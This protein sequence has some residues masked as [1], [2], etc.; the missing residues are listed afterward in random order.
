M[1]IHIAFIIIWSHFQLESVI[2]TYLDEIAYLGEIWKK[3]NKF[4]V[5]S[6]FIYIL[7]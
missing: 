2:Y 4:Q 1:K 5:S 7:P 6:D 3:G